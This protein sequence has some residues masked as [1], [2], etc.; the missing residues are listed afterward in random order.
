MS[1]V[2]TPRL[3]Q[4]R[5]AV[6]SG[7]EHKAFIPYTSVFADA[8]EPDK[9]FVIQARVQSLRPNHVTLDRDW[10][11]TNR[12]MFDY[13]VVATGTRL[14]A[15]GT[16]P[17]DDKAEGVKYLQNHQDRVKKAR[18]IVIVGGGAIG[19]QMATDIKEIYP[20]K[21]V[22]LVHSRALLM[23]AFHPKMDEILRARLGELGVEFVY[24]QKS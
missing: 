3:I 1:S 24:T 22:T 13:A 18:K 17:S 4:P 9:H 11:G 23:H 14:P 10:A 8:P 2:L 6:A 16:I 15:P 5:F 7:Y 20:D 21:H 19:V 12:L